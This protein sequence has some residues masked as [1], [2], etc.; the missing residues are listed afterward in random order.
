MPPVK[1]GTEKESAG[2]VEAM[3]SASPRWWLLS[4]NLCT[5]IIHNVCC[6]GMDVFLCIEKSHFSFLP[7]YI[8]F[9]PKDHWRLDSRSVEV[10][11]CR[12]NK[13]RRQDS[14]H[15]AKPFLWPCGAR[16]R[17]GFLERKRGNL[18]HHSNFILDL[19]GD[20]RVDSGSHF[21]GWAS[22]SLP[23]TGYRPP[24]F[25][26]FLFKIEFLPFESKPSPKLT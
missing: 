11:N 20:V 2:H 5:F 13:Y 9:T 21:L 19:E 10:G 16:F 18:E 12:V 15:G 22:R 1:A 26:L 25:N 3:P 17:Q 24:V 8:F 4:W 6:S 23:F 7:L 14:E